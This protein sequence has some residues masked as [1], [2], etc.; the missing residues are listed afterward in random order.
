[1]NKIKNSLI[2]FWWTTRPQ[3]RMQSSTTVHF[4]WF[5]AFEIVILWV[6][7]TIIVYYNIF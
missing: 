1:M 3:G 2:H 5:E 7:F 4:G 6:Y